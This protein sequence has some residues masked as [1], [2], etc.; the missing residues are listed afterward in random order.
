VQSLASQSDSSTAEDDDDLDAPV[1]KARATSP[2]RARKPLG[3]VERTRQFS[4][5]S[6]S[7][8]GLPEKVVR[9]THISKNQKSETARNKSK[10]ADD[11][12]DDFMLHAL[13]TP[14]SKRAKPKVGLNAKLG[15][16]SA[17]KIGS[18]NEIPIFLV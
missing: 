14:Y 16:V 1:S 5:W 4:P 6:S 17:E 18:V 15:E 7:L 13:S 10:I 11:D 8:P 3:T 12:L 9:S 2:S